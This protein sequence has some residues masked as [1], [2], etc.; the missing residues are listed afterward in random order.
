[1]SL[2]NNYNNSA[3]LVAEAF[4]P[5]FVEFAAGNEKLHNV[6]EE[7][8]ADFVSTAIPVV[9]DDAQHDVAVELLM[10]T[11]VCKV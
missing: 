8:A 6:L 10:S 9:S 5:D 11:T 2:N 7:I 1:M 4:M 3:R